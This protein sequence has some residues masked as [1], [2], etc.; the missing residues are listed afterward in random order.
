[1]TIFSFIQILF[2]SLNNCLVFHYGFWFLLF[3]SFIILNI[4]I[5]QSFRMFIYEKLLGCYLSCFLCVWKIA[6]GKLFFVLSAIFISD[7]FTGE[8]PIL[9]AWVVGMTSK[10]GFILVLPGTL[11][12]SAAWKLFLIYLL[13]FWLGIAIQCGW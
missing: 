12:A 11:E 5:L 8:N 9:T 10:R 4:L 2:G 6:H 3:F 1:M 13:I 7:F